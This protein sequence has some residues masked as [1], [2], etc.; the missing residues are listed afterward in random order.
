MVGGEYLRILNCGEDGGGRSLLNWPRA[1]L[2]FESFSHTMALGQLPELAQLSSPHRALS[3]RCLLYP[4]RDERQ[5][6]GGAKGGSQVCPGPVRL[7]DTPRTVE[8]AHGRHSGDFTMSAKNLEAVAM[9]RGKPSIGAFSLQKPATRTMGF[10]F[11]DPPDPRGRRKLILLLLYY[12][13]SFFSI[14]EEWRRQS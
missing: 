9:F 2:K 14:W 10:S 8:T 3:P 11:S 5:A 13:I 7:G 12:I 4:H 6:F 1:V